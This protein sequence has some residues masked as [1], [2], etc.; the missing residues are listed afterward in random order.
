MAG[1][2]YVPV[3]NQVV[4]FAPGESFKEVTVQIIPS[5]AYSGVLEL[6]CHIDESSAEGCSVGKYLHTSTIKI[7]DV[8]NTFP[9]KKLEKFV[10]YGNEEAISRVSPSRLIY[11]FVALCWANP[12][13]RQGSIK[14]IIAHQYQSARA[15]LNILIMLFVVRTLQ[16]GSKSS[17]A[18][19]R[20]MIIYGAMWF[21]P[22]LLSH[23]LSFQ[24]NF[25]KVGGSLKKQYQVLLLKKF[26]NYTDVSRAEVST[27][28]VMRCPPFDE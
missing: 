23:Y 10:K 12:V 19:R 17:E 26:L 16:D 14:M 9:T 24:Q 27:E 22:F 3:K 25:W 8:I 28:Q 7:I 2:N 15:V 11:N 5:K 18:K 13:T 4:E 1:M 21:F 6:G 20:E